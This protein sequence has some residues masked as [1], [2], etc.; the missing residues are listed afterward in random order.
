[1]YGLG[2]WQCLV[3]LFHVSCNTVRRK[4]EINIQSIPLV[5]ICNVVVRICTFWNKV[6]QKE[7]IGPSICL[8]PI[9][10]KRQLGTLLN[11][12]VC[13]H[14]FKWKHRDIYLFPC[15]EFYEIYAILL[16][17]TIQYFFKKKSR[18]GHFAFET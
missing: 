11:F 4:N 18:K 15:I 8:L 17:H 6:L 2:S 12:C 7:A 14:T 5:Y 10:R 16:E 13:I 1:M 3:S 9:Y